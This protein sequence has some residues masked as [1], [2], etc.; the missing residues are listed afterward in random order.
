MPQEQ[1]SPISRSLSRRRSFRYEVFNTDDRGWT[2]LHIGARKGDLK[3][4]KRLLND[5]MDVNSIAWGPKSKGL[6]PLH[7]AAEGGHLEVMDELLERGANIDARTK[8]ACGWTPL[9]SAA[10][11]RRK[12]AVKFL[13]EN[14]AFLPDDINDCRFNPPLH[15]CPGLEWAYEE[16]KRL[17]HDNSSSEETSCSSES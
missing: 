7:L 1:R 16:M 5:G 2:S 10:K 12:E 8:G 15:Y 13:V 3:E 4:V 6:T 17:H 11:E 14:G 9:H